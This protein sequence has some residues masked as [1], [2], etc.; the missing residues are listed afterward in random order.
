M[1]NQRKPAIFE[2]RE[3]VMLVIIALL[4]PFVALPSMLGL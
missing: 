2:R 3:D 1:S 4:V